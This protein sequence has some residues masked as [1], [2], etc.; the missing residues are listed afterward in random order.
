[1]ARDVADV[2]AYDARALW[3]RHLRPELRVGSLTRI[4][5][6]LA[7][8]AVT[9]YPLI[10]IVSTALKNPVDV[11][12]NPFSLFSSFRPQNIVDAWTLGEFGHY[13]FNT[14]IITVPTT[15]AVVALSIATGYALARLD[16]PGRT[17]VFYIFMLGLM[18]PF[19]SIMIPL[20]YHLRGLGLLNHFSG[21]ILPAVAGATGYGLPLGVFLMRAF[22]YD[23]PDELADA[24]R[25]DGAGEF[26]VFRYAMLPLAAPGASVLTVLVFIQA[27]KEFILPL[28]YL[29]N[30]RTLSTGI[31]LFTSGRTSETELA[32]AASLIM[33]VPVVLV[34]LFFQRQFIRGLT[35]GAL[36]G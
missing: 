36:K 3:V 9:L 16:F 8:L 12:A 18:I 35:A 22:F 30:T 23:L 21:V 20:Y 29:Q 2:R 5:V 15:A 11:T 28:I 26:H 14:V 27:W 25:V 19:F 34:F 33:T 10:L 17:L 24:A 4:V 13:F 32:A 31:F 1:M 6:L 7:F